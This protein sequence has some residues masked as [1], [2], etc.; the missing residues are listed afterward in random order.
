LISTPILKDDHREVKSW[1][2][3]FDNLDD[4]TKETLAKRICLALTIHAQIEE[5]L[6]YPALRKALDEEDLLD[7]AEVEHATA[8]QLIPRK[9]NL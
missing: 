6:F 7:E 2:K 4:T 1:F 5:E 8:K 9:F 3:E